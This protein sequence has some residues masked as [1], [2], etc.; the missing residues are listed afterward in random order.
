[1]AFSHPSGNLRSVI[2]YLNINYIVLQITDL[3]SV[4]DAGDLILDI[5]ENGKGSTAWQSY[6]TILNQENLCRSLYTSDY[7]VLV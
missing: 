1:M 3:W 7:R 6:V 4:L 5:S 2:K